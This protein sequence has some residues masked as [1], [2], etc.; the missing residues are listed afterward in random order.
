M[1]D[2]GV[3]GRHFCA[4]GVAGFLV[5]SEESVDVIKMSGAPVFFYIPINNL[6]R[7]VRQIAFPPSIFGL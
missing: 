1:F 6:L 5:G 2:D 4:A 3:S 7:Y